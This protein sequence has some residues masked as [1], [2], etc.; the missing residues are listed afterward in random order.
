[1]L[2]LPIQFFWGINSCFGELVPVVFTGLGVWGIDPV[3]NSGGMVHQ[4]SNMSSHEVVVDNVKRMPAL[5]GDNPKDR[6][7][8]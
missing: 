7:C 8:H 3:I 1:M 6:R 2:Q 4:E 5:S